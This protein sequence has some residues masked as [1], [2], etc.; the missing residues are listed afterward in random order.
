MDRGA[1]GATVHGV[2]KSRTRLSDFTFAFTLCL[3]EAQVFPGV[4]RVVCVCVLCVWCVC[5][6][7]SRSVVPHSLGLLDRGPPGSFV[8]RLLQAGVRVAIPF[9]RISPPPKNQTRV[10]CIAGRFFTV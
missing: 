7:V 6:Y 2:T 10:F 9:S 5:V 3:P 1:C 4:S 8:Y